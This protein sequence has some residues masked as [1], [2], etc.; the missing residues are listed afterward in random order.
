MIQATAVLAAIVYSGVVS[1][2][3]LKLIWLVIPLRATEARRGQGLD[4]T[5]TARKPICTDG[6]GRTHLSAMSGDAGQ[7]AHGVDR[8]A[9]WEPPRRPYSRR[10][11]YATGPM[12]PAGQ[13]RNNVRRPVFHPDSRPDFA[14]DRGRESCQ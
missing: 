6:G 10:P 5:R 3:L 1:F 8:G 9:R 11:S 13:K 2:V 14:S 7:A 4:I 12:E